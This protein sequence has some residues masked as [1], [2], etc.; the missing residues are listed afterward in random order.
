MA[1]EGPNSPDT[2]VDDATIGTVAW[3]NPGNVLASDDSRAAVTL[4]LNA[5]SHYLKVTDFDFAIPAGSAINGIVVEVERQSN[6]T[7][8]TRDEQVRLVQGGTVGGNN[9]ADTVTVWPLNTDTIATYGGAA[10]LWGLTW[11]PADINA[12]DFG[13]V[14]AAKNYDVPNRT[15][16]VD[17]I[18]ITV[19]YAVGGGQPTRTM[20]QARHR[21]V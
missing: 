18:R 12:T 3:N 20:H 1:S 19:Y 11:T 14:V 9:K 8:G 5:I 7:T 15:A 16:R 2:A 21:R 4:S 6:A 10:D 13:A 17:H